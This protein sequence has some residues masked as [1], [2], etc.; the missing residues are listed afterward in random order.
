ME[1]FFMAV[2][3]LR[4]LEWLLME[5]RMGRR[6]LATLVDVVVRDFLLELL[7]AQGQHSRHHSGLRPGLVPSHGSQFNWISMSEMGFKR[8]SKETLGYSG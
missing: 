6:L 1:T 4:W 3:W 5:W 7:Q 8:P 2:E